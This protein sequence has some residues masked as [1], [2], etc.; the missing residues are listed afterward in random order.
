M[1]QIINS[2]SNSPYLTQLNDWFTAEWGE[3]NVYNATRFNHNFPLPLLA[4]E[5]D[6]LLGGLAFTR[7]KNPQNQ[8]IA[9]WV[10]ALWVAPEHRGKGI[11]VSLLQSAEQ[12]ATQLNETQLFAR[13]NVPQLYQKN[14]WLELSQD[15][16]DKIMSKI[17]KAGQTDKA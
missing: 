12:V 16:D 10:N 2:H 4:I 3:F 9:L 11:A 8:N 6:K 5:Q 14:A 7:Y 1:V 13:T 15:G 17:I